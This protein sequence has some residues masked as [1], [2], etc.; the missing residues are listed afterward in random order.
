LRSIAVIALACLLATG[1]LPVTV[2]KKATTPAK[3]KSAAKTN[4]K[5][6]AKSSVKTA[7]KAGAKT[8]VASSAKSSATKKTATAAGKTPSK[9]V[10]TKT[11]ASKKRGKKAPVQS[12]RARQQAPTPDRYKQIQEAL[13]AKGYL[14]AEPS[15]VWN[16]ESTDA[17]RRFQADQKLEPSG[18]LNSLSLIALGLGPRRDTAPVPPPQAR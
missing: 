18:K 11:A 15:G 17:L 5:S 16:G 9:T 3:K 2:D 7:T 13:A 10:G 12:W 8:G 1:A 14:K 4:A 6:P